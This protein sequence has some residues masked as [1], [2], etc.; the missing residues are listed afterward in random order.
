MRNAWMVPI[1][2]S[3]AALG[4]DVSTKQGAEVH[5]N[6]MT[7]QPLYEHL[8]EG[9]LAE[10]NG[11]YKLRV[12]ESVYVPGGKIGDHHHAGPGVRMVVSGELTYIQV[13]KT[14]IYKAGDCFFESGDV[15]H[16]AVNNGKEPVKLINFEL[17]PADWKSASAIV[18][19]EGAP[20]VER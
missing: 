8:V 10:L 16:T 6:G 5:R 1:L 4:A 3:S 7:S 15:S 2:I 17:L 9:K 14:T 12:S 18:V 20:R 13:G 19:P 11:K